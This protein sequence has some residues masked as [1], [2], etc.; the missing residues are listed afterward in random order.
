LGSKAMILEL[1][2]GRIQLVV[3]SFWNQS[4]MTEKFV[5]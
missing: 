5:N 3:I 4:L 2:P 1:K